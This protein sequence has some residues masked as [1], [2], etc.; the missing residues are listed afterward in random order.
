MGGK[1]KENPLSAISHLFSIPL[2]IVCYLILTLYFVKLQSPDVKYSILLNSNDS[3]GSFNSKF[4]S[5]NQNSFNSQYSHYSSH[6]LGCENLLARFKISPIPYITIIL[7]GLMLP[8]P[9]SIF[10]QFLVFLKSDFVAQ[11]EV[12]KFCFIP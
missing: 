9:G 6:R 11:F 2:C 5:Q 7:V 8:K 4:F 3:C 10:L 1:K 12:R